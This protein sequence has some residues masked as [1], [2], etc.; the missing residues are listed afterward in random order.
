[1]KTLLKTL[2]T[3]IDIIAAFACWLTGWYLLWVVV[4]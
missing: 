1:M 3:N 4:K 2:I